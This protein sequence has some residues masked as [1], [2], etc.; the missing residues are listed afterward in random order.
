MSIVD[1]KGNAV[2]SEKA[3]REYRIGDISLQTNATPGLKLQEALEGAKKIASMQLQASAQQQATTR[4]IALPEEAIKVQILAEVSK[5][6]DPFKMEPAAQAVFMLLADEISKRD[7]LIDNLTK[8]LEK[9]EC[10]SEE[11]KLSLSTDGLQN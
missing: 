9:L 7:K 6:V 3:L 11:E 5:I 1:P 4:G 8:R 10:L 2:A